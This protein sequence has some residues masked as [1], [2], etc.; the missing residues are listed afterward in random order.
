MA[1]TTTP[2]LVLTDLI[3]GSAG[4]AARMNNNMR[5]MEAALA[6][7]ILDRDLS[8]PPGGDSAGDCYIAASSPSG[9][10]SDFSEGDIVFYTGSAWIGVTPPDGT[11]KWIDDEAVLVAFDGTNWNRVVTSAETKQAV[12]RIDSP[13]VDDQLPIMRTLRAITI[14]SVRTVV[15]G[16][17]TPS[18]DFNIM[19]NSN[20]G[21]AGTQVFTSDQTA[22]NETTG[23]VFNSGFNDETIAADRFV[24]AEMEG[25]P[26]GTVDW[27]E[28]YI[29]YTEDAP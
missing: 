21:A 23:N 14:T 7:P 8:T 16:S 10:W 13:V 9:D 6:A 22:D 4:Q 1:D 11:I 25:A 3:E 18:I 19:H 2:T 15:G 24:W 28:F 26:S 20:R 17:S 5:L 27:V 12:V 29:E